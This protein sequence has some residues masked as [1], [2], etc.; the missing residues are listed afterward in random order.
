MFHHLN[1]RSFS[2]HTGLVEASGSNAAGRSRCVLLLKGR[3]WDVQRFRGE[4]LQIPC[5]EKVGSGP[6][7]KF[8]YDEISVQPLLGH[9]AAPR[10]CISLRAWLTTADL[11][12]GFHVGCLTPAEN[13][14]C[15]S[16]IHAK[17]V[18]SL[19]C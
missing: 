10:L 16:P 11:L 14:G 1:L 3:Q 7:A 6:L 9:F 4:M 2:R 5:D 19:P 12:F 8:F 13:P 15:D 17:I 18:S